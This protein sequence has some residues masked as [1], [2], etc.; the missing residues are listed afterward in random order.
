MN[1]FDNYKQVKSKTP[2]ERKLNLISYYL[3]RPLGFALTAF[4]I[5]TKITPNQVTLLNFVIT[6]ISLFLIYISHYDQIIFI[7]FRNIFFSHLVD[8]V[9]GV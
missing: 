3:F 8:N 5:N 6:S 2:D 4:I 9:D 1:F 7:W